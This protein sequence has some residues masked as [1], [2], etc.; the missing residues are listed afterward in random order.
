MNIIGGSCTPQLIDGGFFAS[1]SIL[2]VS[3]SF[4][5]AQFTSVIPYLGSM[6]SSIQKLAKVPKITIC[7][8]KT[9]EPVIADAISLITLLGSL[10]NSSI[11]LKILPPIMRNQRLAN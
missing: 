1:S 4:W 7:R 10:S 6:D 11:W 5:I 2:C 9:L 3:V 8:K